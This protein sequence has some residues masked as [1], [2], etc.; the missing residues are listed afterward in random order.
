MTETS[1][2][3]RALLVRRLR[4]VVTALDIN[5]DAEVGKRVRDEVRARADTA[6]AVVG[7][8]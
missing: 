2:M 4:I 8:A 6:S 5:L 3:E 7:E 1:L